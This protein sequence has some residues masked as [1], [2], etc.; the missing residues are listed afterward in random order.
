MKVSDTDIRYTVNV[1]T[2]YV[3]VHTGIFSSSSS[4]MRAE[5]SSPTLS[6][7]LSSR[8]PSSLPLPSD[9]LL[10]FL[11][12]NRSVEAGP[13]N[14]MTNIPGVYFTIRQ[15]LQIFPPLPF[16]LNDRVRNV[17]HFCVTSAKH[18]CSS[19]EKQSW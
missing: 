2:I 12:R 5:V 6:S 18:E 4:S 1:T 19:R 8:L 17:L 9:L 3:S 11:A 10:C 7:L 14:K 13:E 15:S 16:L